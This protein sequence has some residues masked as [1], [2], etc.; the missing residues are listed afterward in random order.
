[1]AATKENEAALKEFGITINGDGTL[2]LNEKKLATADVSKVKDFFDGNAA[3]SY[4][5]KVATRLNRASNYVK[6]VLC[7]C[8]YQVPPICTFQ[9]IL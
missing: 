3:M 2:S 5:S 6:E 8:R 7:L 4:G 1:M 9:C